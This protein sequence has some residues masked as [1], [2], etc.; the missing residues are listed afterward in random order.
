MTDAAI[1][2]I[3]IGLGAFAATFGLIML[4]WAR[5]FSSAFG[6]RGDAKEPLVDDTDEI[7]DTPNDVDP[8]VQEYLAFKK[9]GQSAPINMSNQSIYLMA[10]AIF[11]G[12]VGLT[13]LWSVP[14]ATD[15]RLAAENACLQWF[16][17][18]WELGGSDEFSSEV[19][20]KDGKVVVEIGFD[21][22]GTSYN[23][24]LCVFD[25]ETGRMQAPNT[26][27]RGRWE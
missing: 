1:Y 19:W 6:Q 22:N 18:D 14:P 27:N 17:D 23:T 2:S 5:I 12:L 11:G 20:E 8:D 13:Y 21:D 9:S 16:K 3:M 4:P 26:F 25:P 7:F 15:E 10:V 24:R